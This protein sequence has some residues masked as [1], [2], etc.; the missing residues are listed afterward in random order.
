MKKL[1]YTTKN[2]GSTPNAIYDE[3]LR[4][5]FLKIYS[6]MS[7]GLAITA[8]SAFA[9]FS[10]PLLTHMMFNICTERLFD[11]HDWYRMADYFCSTGYL[12]VFCFWIR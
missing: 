10:V 4:Q 12:T 3:G 7:S 8:I 11:R 9:V 2:Y 5:Y 1:H 6:L